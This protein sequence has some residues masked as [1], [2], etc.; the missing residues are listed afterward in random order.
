MILSN[1]EVNQKIYVNYL[2]TNSKLNY[3]III[4]KSYIP[5]ISRWIYSQNRVK[6]INTIENLINI[7]INQINYFEYI[8]NDELI[9]KFFN[10]LDKSVKG[11][12]NLKITYESDNENSNKIIKIINKIDEYKNC[13]NYFS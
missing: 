4:D 12:Q 7:T 9:D 6:T 5:Q 1:L 2:A 11:L 8:K 3:E 13:K 10:L